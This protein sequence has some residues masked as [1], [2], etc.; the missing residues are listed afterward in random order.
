MTTTHDPSS[1]ALPAEMVAKRARSIANTIRAELDHISNPTEEET[2]AVT[3]MAELLAAWTYPAPGDDTNAALVA[4]T[5]ADSKV[6]AI[7][8]RNRRRVVMKHTKTYGR[9]DYY[10]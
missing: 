6:Q 9:P 7:K 1:A 2:A 3:A 4:F 8:R 5:D 10:R